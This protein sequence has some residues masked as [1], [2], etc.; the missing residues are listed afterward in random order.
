MTKQE[1]GKELQDW[2]KISN[3]DYYSNNQYLQGWSH[4][5]QYLIEMLNITFEIDMGK[6]GRDEK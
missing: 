6:E 2:M 3:E 5:M 1:L 4:G